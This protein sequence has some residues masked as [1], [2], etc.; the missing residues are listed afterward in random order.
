MKFKRWYDSLVFEFLYVAE[1]QFIGSD[2]QTRSFGIIIEK[3]LVDGALDEIRSYVWIMIMMY[4]FFFYYNF[5]TLFIFT[6]LGFQPFFTCLLH[7][8]VFCYSS[9]CLFLIKKKKS[10]CLWSLKYKIV[11]L[12]RKISITISQFWTYLYR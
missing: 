3:N 9:P 6:F 11:L 1:N 10:P 12:H 7:M 8:C 4:S 2:L 5:F